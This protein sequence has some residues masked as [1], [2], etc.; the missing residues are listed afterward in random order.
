MAPLAGRRARTFLS[1][2]VWLG[3]AG[4]A[5]W[6]Y[7]DGVVGADAIAIAQI[8]EYRV[9]PAVLGRLVSLDVAE[10][11]RVTAGQVVARLETRM[12]E[13][14]LSVAEA[15]LQYAASEVHATGTSLDIGFL[16]T[17]RAFESEI[18][19]VRV[20][21]EAARASSA[22]DSAEF[23]KVRED[24][25]RQRDL[26]RRGLAKA[27]RIGELDLRRAALD[28]AVK[29]WP[30]RIRS[31]DARHQA[32][33]ARLA[34]W[35]RTREAG[36]GGARNTQIQPARERVREQKESVRLLGARLDETVLRAGCDAYV[37]SILARPGDVVRAGDPVV[38][39]VEARPRQ[40]IAWIEERKGEAPAVGALVVARRTAGGR[41]RFQATVASVTT[42]VSQLPQRLWPN[43]HIPAWGRAIY[44][45][46]PEPASV[47][48]GE[49]LDVR[50]HPS[51]Q[52]AARSVVSWKTRMGLHADGAAR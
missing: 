1:L 47:D 34:E 3:A 32:A 41:E 16:Q 25:D 52:P 30:P 22:R 33:T 37:A 13:R 28:E 24:L 20:E 12:L 38:T 15:R 31:L 29:A 2:G 46:L 49:T 48:P 27:D 23:A 8:K 26:V 43:P 50:L 14:E 19:A 35:R 39:L 40:A 42:Q 5:Y 4:V 45:N 17:E 44:L 36:P 7:R 11:D 51:A 10:G 6:L 9:A 18:E 21:M